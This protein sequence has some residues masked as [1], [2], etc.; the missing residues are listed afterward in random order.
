MA[1]A[2]AGWD[3]VEVMTRVANLRP[4]TTYHYRVVAT[5]DSGTSTGPMGEFTT[6]P[7]RR[8]PSSP[9]RSWPTRT[10]RVRFKRPGGRWRPLRDW[11]GELPVGVAL[12]TRRGSIKL[13][14]VGRRRAR[15]QTGTFGGGVVKVRQP[16]Y[17]PRPR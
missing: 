13:T 11:G 15:T 2:G 9:P 12:D 17:G 4:A 10:G 7:S 16:R 6:R 3:H 8:S 1:S 14:S 5:N